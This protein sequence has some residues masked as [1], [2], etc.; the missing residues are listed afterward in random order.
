MKNE[1]KQKLNNLI[2][3]LNYQ[4]KEM[5]HNTQ[6][7]NKLGFNVEHKNLIE[8]REML[9]EIIYKLETIRDEE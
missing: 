1:T 2:S 3:D 7:A 8:K 6:V 4:R 9:E 5:M